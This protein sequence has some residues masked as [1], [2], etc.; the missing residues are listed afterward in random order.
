MI[1]MDKPDKNTQL[2]QELTDSEHEPRQDVPN[3]FGQFLLKK[4]LIT[5][6]DLEQAL[7]VQRQQGGRLGEVLI[8]SGVLSEPEALEAL[9][10]HL[11][12]E[13]WELDD[14]SKIDMTMAR[15]LPEGIA[16]RFCVLPIEEYEGRIRIVMADPVDVMAIDTV[17]LR[18]HRRILPTLCARSRIVK[19]IEVVYHGS[20]VEEARLR[21]LVQE[22]DRDEDLIAEM[23]SLSRS[24]PSTDGDANDAPVVQFVDL[25][26][27]QAVKSEASDIHVEPQEN[28]MCIRMRVDGKLR[29]MVPPPRKMQAAVVARLKILSQ[30]NIAERRLP[31]DGRMKIG[32]SGRDIDVRVSAIP[33][34]YGEKVVLRILDNAATCHDLDQL[35]FAE[36]KLHEFKQALALPHGI[37]I[38]TGPTGSGKTTTLYAALNHLKNPAENI[39]TV[40]D[41]VEYRLEGINQIQIK[42]EIG[43]NFAT[44]LRAILRQDPDIVLIGEIRDKET[45]DIAIKASLTG[46]LVLSTF[47][48]NDAASAISRLSYMGIER[49]L[50]ASTLNLVVAQRLVRRICE[51]CKEPVTIQEPVLQRLGL[52]ENQIRHATICSGK[53]CSACGGTGYKGRMPIFEFLSVDEDVAE[54]IV[55]EANESR[56]RK[57]AYRKGGGSLID[58]GLNLVLQGKTTVEEVLSVAYMGRSVME[59]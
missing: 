39:T 32:V 5:P 9:A 13:Y 8:S 10:E 33:T 20:Q 18:L 11:R 41:P 49:Y 43:L 38:V 44:C 52:N 37:I 29:D 59:D 24:D 57:L 14:L 58:S 45:V 21:E 3:T 16:R 46:H 23:T 17:M 30:L 48:T 51:R 55:S 40:E 42:P 50:L 19:A 28:D 27:R 12:M 7:S 2:I 47:H 26:L 4:G 34:I 1:P 54:M 56:I 6:Q 15:S 36:D 53:G 25:L 35:G 31:Q 22:E